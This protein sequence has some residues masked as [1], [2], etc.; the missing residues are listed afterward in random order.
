MHYLL[1]VMHRIEAESAFTS[2]STI[3]EGIDNDASLDVTVV[4]AFLRLARIP[5][6]KRVRLMFPGYTF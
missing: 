1:P 3:F 5:C 4:K 6:R 2:P